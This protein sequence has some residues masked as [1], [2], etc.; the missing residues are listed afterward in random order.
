MPESVSVEAPDLVRLLPPLMMPD[1]VASAEL[2]T[3]ALPLSTMAL[4]M[5]VA[6]VI[7]SVEPDASVTELPPRLLSLATDSVPADTVVVPE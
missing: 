7:S 2:L 6:P 4:S 5:L 3:V 1:R